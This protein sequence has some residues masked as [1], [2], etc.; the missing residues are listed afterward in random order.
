MSMTEQPSVAGSREDEE[1]PH[2]F[3]KHAL[4][5]QGS[6]AAHSGDY[7]TGN[8]SAEE[9]FDI[10]EYCHADDDWE[11]H[12]NTPD[13]ACYVDSTHSRSLGRIVLRS[14]Q[15]ISTNDEVLL[16]GVEKYAEAT[17][18]SYRDQ[19]RAIQ[20]PYKP[21]PLGQS[22]TTEYFSHMQS[23]P[24]YTTDSPQPVHLSSSKYEPYRARF[25]SSESASQH[26]KEATRFSRKP[27]RLPGTDHTIREVER[28]RL[29]HVE[30][31]YNAMTCGDAARDNKGSIAMKRWVHG[32]YYNS[33]LVEAYAHKVI[34]CLLLQAKDGFRGWV[35]FLPLDFVRDMTNS[36]IVK[37]HNDYVADDRKGDD[38][39]RDVTCEERLESVLRALQEEKTICEDVMNSACQIRMF[40]NAPKA[41]ANRKYQN[42][43]GNSKRGRTKD[44]D[45]SDGPSKVR[46][47]NPKPA[48]R[49]RR[50][51]SN[52]LAEVNVHMRLGSQPRET[53]PFQ[54]Q[55]RFST[56]SAFP[57]N[58]DMA[59][60]PRLVPL[61]GD[62]STRSRFQASSPP[63]TGS[64]YAPRVSTMPPQQHTPLMSPPA[65]TH[66]NKSAPTSPYDAHPIHNPD[67]EPWPAMQYGNV[68]YRA[69]EPLFD[70]TWSSPGGP[71]S[72]ACT[73]VD[74]NLF[75]QHPELAE[76][77]LS[78]RQQLN[79]AYDGLDFSEYWRAQHGVQQYPY[80]GPS[81]THDQR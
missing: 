15:Q 43:V 79:G 68:Y 22:D 66:G 21:L 67:G 63:L 77:T 26:R 32:A 75:A 40:V 59:R 50:T 37:V 2:G 13:P 80:P 18:L 8:R 28:D 17:S 10:S 76:V 48:T 20:L 65:L 71:Q 45:A 36:K 51:G 61:Q 57:G 29:Y 47:F 73:G 60:L 6:F 54:H 62:P 14:N 30:R 70:G 34:D 81:N 23:I 3:S 12:A 39:D 35:S 38:E 44:S 5:S 69:D 49:A 4:L 25:D 33:D 46:K 24:K 31:V 16:S 55:A 41:Y 27:Y 52:K 9:T 42:R 11:P 64:P 58:P 74:A 7:N 72:Q 56:P 1:T 78:P 53:S 19:A